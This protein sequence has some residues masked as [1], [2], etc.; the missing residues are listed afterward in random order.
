MIKQ[1]NCKVVQ[2]SKYL[3]TPNPNKMFYHMTFGLIVNYCLLR[4][5]QFGCFLL[6]PNTLLLVVSLCYNTTNS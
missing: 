1:T 5:L 4:S 3:K 2:Y 6:S